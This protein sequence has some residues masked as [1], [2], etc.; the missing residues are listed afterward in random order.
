MVCLPP[1]GVLLLSP[2]LLSQ[3]IPGELHVQHD[4]LLS[5][6]MERKSI[7]QRPGGWKQRSSLSSHQSKNACCFW[8]FK[9]DTVGRKHSGQMPGEGDREGEGEKVQG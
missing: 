6:V 1:P 9:V 2:T 8:S 5:A 7:C 3:L 4:L